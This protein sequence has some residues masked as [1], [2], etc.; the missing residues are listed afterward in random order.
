[1]SVTRVLGYCYPVTL[2]EHQVSG[3]VGVYPLRLINSAV[4]CVLSDTNP[5][6]RYLP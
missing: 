6:T 4:H 5:S 2:T 1:M 3:Q